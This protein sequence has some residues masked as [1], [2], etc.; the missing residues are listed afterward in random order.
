LPVQT[1]ISSITAPDGTIAV[2]DL[3]NTG[4][5]DE[6]IVNP[7]NPSAT[8]TITRLSAP[9][10]A[11]TGAHVTWIWAGTD[12]SSNPMVVL[13]YS[14]N[15]TY[16]W[17]DRTR[18]WYPLGRNTALFAVGVNG[19]S[20]TLDNGVFHI[21]S[22]PT[23]GGGIIRSVRPPRVGHVET[24]LDTS[25]P[26]LNT[27]NFR[28]GPV[29]RPVLVPAVI[30]EMA[31]GA[32]PQG[33]PTIDALFTG[34]S[35][36][37]WDSSNGWQLLGTGVQ[38]VDAGPGGSSALVLTDGTLEILVKGAG[39]PPTFPL[40]GAGLPPVRFVSFGT[41]AQGGP[42]IDFQFQGSSIVDEA[43]VTT[44]FSAN[45]LAVNSEGMMGHVISAWAAGIG[46][47]SAA[48]YDD[49]NLSLLIDSTSP[50]MTG[51]AF[52]N[53]FLVTLPGGYSAL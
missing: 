27:S 22:D 51:S 2:Y 20:V 26:D 30:T 35:A 11:A 53:H 38:A 44:G 14:D 25:P 28:V 10:E 16:E 33:N 52:L 13:E 5:V 47:V 21:H 8:P 4:V 9:N 42:M 12:S 45:A 19:Y 36:W 32:D 6:L 40:Q 46:G 50:G 43:N 7:A 29:R 41:N 23:T 49:G 15:N 17:S 39:S 31:V 3:H 18:Q 1:I 37:S 48:V 24:V 34:G